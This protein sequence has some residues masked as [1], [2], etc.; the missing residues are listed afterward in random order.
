MS[1]LPVFDYRSRIIDSLERG[2]SLIVKAPT[3][4][5]KST[6]V[7][8]FLLDAGVFEGRILI[9][10]PRR[11]AARML[12]AR[13][14]EERGVEVGAEI[15][16]QTRF[17]T[18]FSDATRACFITEGILPRML[19]SNRELAGVSVIIFDEFHERNLATDIGLALAAHLRRT[20]RPDLRLIVMSATID[21]TPVAQYLGDADV[22]DCPGRAHPIDIRY[23]SAPKAA[24]PWDTAADAVRSLVAGGEEGDILVFMP[25]AYEI[26]R[27]MRAIDQTVRGEPIS[28]VPLYG[29]L[30]PN[31][32]R[33]VMEKVSRRKIIVSTNIAETSLTI[34][35]V[36]H[37]VDSGLARV[38][39]YDPARGF[40]TLFVEPISRDCADQRAGRAG[41]EAPGVCIRLW[42]MPQHAG[43]G[44]RTAPEVAR[45]DLTETLLQLR[46]LG[47]DATDDFPWFEAPDPS[48]LQSAHALLRLLGAL[49]PGGDLTETGKV[50]CRFPMH[51]RLAR[52][53]LE[54]GKRGAVRPATFTAALLSERPAISGKPEYPDSACRRE[55]ASDLY[56]HYCLLEKVRMSGFDPAI[57]TRF[58]VNA[59][60]AQAIF[61]TQALFLH[62]CRRSGMS[63]RDAD[64]AP[65]ALARSLLTAFPDHLAV[66][67]DKGTLFCALREGRRGELAKESLART[68]RLLAATD[69]REIKTPKAGLKTILTLATEIKEEWL[70]EDFPHAWTTL[71]SLEWNPAA[72]AVE[73]Q[74]RI[75]CLGVPLSRKT[76]AEVDT[77]HAAALLADAVISKGLKLHSWDQGVE[78]W[79]RRVQWVARLFPGRRLPCFTDDDRRSAVRRLCEGESR[80]ERVKDKPVIPVLRGLFDRAQLDFIDAMAPQAIVLP[81]GRKMALSYEPGS[82]PRGRARIQDLY[83]LRATPK[84]AEGKAA[85]LI[86]ILAPNNRPVQI[87]D[88]LGRFWDVHYPGIKKAL[89]RRY[90]KHEWR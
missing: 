33:Q 88:D 46:L 38:N 16:F 3:G 66:R 81:S 51:P 75:L 55:I 54:A 28:I 86:E 50:L 52:L 78:A 72:G 9:L 22:I 11:L 17:E 76:G 40:N 80:Y 47:Y 89:S 15:G 73:Q 48:A 62:Y 4:S 44:M 45:V 24:P 83:N 26:R 74:T 8:Q 49:T 10:Q 63:T 70:H 42:S 7:P 56:G 13:V 53:L 32:Q 82:A 25:G 87:T 61:R 1:I 5:G 31:R 43:R 79:I 14:A 19:L 23:V 41:R 6:Q 18:L 67:L 27:S 20:R 57:C 36:R 2:K 58:A 68:A 60:A 29:D 30:P 84:I 77:R 64:N 65:E 34:P 69:I 21:T 85:I 12:A 59:S 90:P 37:V 35:G 71:S 39:R